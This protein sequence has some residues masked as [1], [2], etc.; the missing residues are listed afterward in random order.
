M[1]PEERPK[2][3]PLLESLEDQL[4]HLPR[5]AVPIGLQSKLLAAIPS[6]ALSPFPHSRGLRTRRLALIAVATA[7]TTAACWILTTFWP[8]PKS[9][10]VEFNA[11]VKVNEVVTSH[12]NTARPSTGAVRLVDLMIN[13]R[14]FEG[15][16]K[17]TF[18]WPVPATSRLMVSSTIPPDLLD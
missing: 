17:T 1:Q 7:L 4:R 11:T 18:A 16:E 15:A 13:P 2:S 12:V 14:E 10:V 5:P 8:G 3:E 6:H 9:D